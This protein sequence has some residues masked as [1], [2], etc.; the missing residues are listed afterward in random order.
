MWLESGIQ[1]RNPPKIRIR[2]PRESAFFWTDS[3]KN[4]NPVQK[5]DG[6]PSLILISYDPL[7]DCRPHNVFADPV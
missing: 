3:C 5:F 2:N 4:P 1:I 7:L 6:L